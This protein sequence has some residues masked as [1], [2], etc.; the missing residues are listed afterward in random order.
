MEGL[1]LVKEPLCSNPK[2]L[3]PTNHLTCFHSS[4]TRWW[5]KMANCFGW[6]STH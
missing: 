4:T 2:W 3:Y 6:T 5:C 1:F